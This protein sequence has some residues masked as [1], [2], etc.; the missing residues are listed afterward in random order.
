MKSQVVLDARSHKL[1]AT[2]HAPGSTND[3]TLLRTADPKLQAHVWVVADGGYQGYAK[4]HRQRCLPIR[5]PR[6]AEPKPED[7]AHNRSLARFRVTVEHTIRS[8]KIWHILKDPYRNRRKRFSL[9]FRLI[10]GLINA[11]LQT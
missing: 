2:A 10:A 11:Q 4:D 8:L 5:K 6:G 3:L 1:L 7:K 9:R